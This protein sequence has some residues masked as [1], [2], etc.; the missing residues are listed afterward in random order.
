MKDCSENKKIAKHITPAAPP[1]APP[2]HVARS[3]HPARPGRATL[4]AG[5]VE[6]GR[7]RTAMCL[8]ARPC[9]RPFARFALFL[10]SRASSN[11]YSSP[12]SSQNANFAN[13]TRRFSL[14]AQ[15]SRNVSK[16]A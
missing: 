1:M 3:C 14:K 15:K 8:D 9:L 2:C 16:I 10:I 11:L 7:W 5:L 13:K 12:Q 6:L 4:L